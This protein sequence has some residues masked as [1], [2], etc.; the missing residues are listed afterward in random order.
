MRT[1]SARDARVHPSFQR[2]PPPRFWSS[3][4]C[5]EIPEIPAVGVWLQWWVCCLQRQ[6]YESDS[7]CGLLRMAVQ[8]LAW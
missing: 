8:A 3:S 6:R 4:V 1:G 5:K 7:A 2:H